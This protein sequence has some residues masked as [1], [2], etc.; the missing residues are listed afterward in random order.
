MELTGPFLTLAIALGVGMLVGLQR[1]RSPSSTHVGGI[2]TFPLVTVLGAMCAML[3]ASFGPW[4]AVVSFAGVVAASILANIIGMK[5][6]DPEPGM[7][8]EV[9]MMVMFVIGVMLASGMRDVAVALGVGTAILLQVKQPLHN[10]A[11]RIGDRDI[12]AVLQFALITFIVLPVLP[13]QTFGPFDVLNPYRIWLM[14]V[15]V[16]GISLAGYIAFRLLGKTNGTLVA[17][18]VG[19]MISSTA[20]TVSYARRARQS[21]EIEGAACAI[22]LLSTL[23]SFGRVITEVRVVAPGYAGEIAMPVVVMAAAAMV[24]AALALMGH[25]RDGGEMPE[26]GNPTELRSALVFGG[27]Y[28]VVLLAVAAAKEYFGDA[29]IYAAAGISGLTDMDAIT[30][31]TG[32]LAERGRLEPGTAWRAIVLASIAN[33]VF[34]TGVVWSLGG[35]RLALRVAAWF[36]VLVAVGVG[37]M[38]FW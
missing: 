11:R 12:H 34:K 17:G 29:G 6:G 9:A 30:L 22:F 13:N 21:R 4:L 38:V 2:R 1:E 31:T 36:G 28:A 35:L 25:G 32:R 7:T 3:S 37:L 16:V 8:T 15:L 19:G 10:W 26:Q 24:C 18:L 23:V 27:L 20:T 33:M 5:R 14:V